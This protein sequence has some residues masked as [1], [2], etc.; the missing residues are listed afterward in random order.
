MEGIDY[1]KNIDML[2]AVLNLSK[3]KKKYENIDEIVSIFA[4]QFRFQASY[5]QLIY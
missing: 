4:K 5:G 1:L 2:E 3:K